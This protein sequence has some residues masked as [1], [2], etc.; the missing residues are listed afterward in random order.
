LEYESFDNDHETIISTYTISLKPEEYVMRLYNFETLKEECGV[1]L[2]PLDVVEPHG[3]V[4]ILG[5]LFLTKYYTVFDRD[6]DI[7]GFALAKKWRY[8]I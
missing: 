2:M 4:W 7:V 6:R 1:G 5:D 8:L 3:P